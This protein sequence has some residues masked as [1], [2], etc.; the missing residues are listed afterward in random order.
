MPLG[1]YFVVAVTVTPNLQQHRSENLQVSQIVGYW[2]F[3]LNLCGQIIFMI[4]FFF[5]FPICVHSHIIC[6]QSFTSFI[7]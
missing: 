4:K 6:M 1:S 7:V 3:Y 2:N 5:K